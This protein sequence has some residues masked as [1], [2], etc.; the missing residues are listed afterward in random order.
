MHNSDYTCAEPVRVTCF[1]NTPLNTESA[2]MIFSQMQLVFVVEN[3]LQL[4]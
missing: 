1:C 3:Y 4:H 2:N